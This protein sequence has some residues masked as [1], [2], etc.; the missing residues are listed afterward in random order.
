M[1][2]VIQ[3]QARRCSSV[4]VHDILPRP[5]ED[6][7]PTPIPRTDRDG[8]IPH[9]HTRSKSFNIGYR[10]GLLSKKV[11]FKAQG[12]LK[13]SDVGNDVPARSSKDVFDAV[14]A[15]EAQHAGVVGPKRGI[16]NEGNTCFLGVLVQCL[17]ATP[18]LA[19]ALASSTNETVVSQE[20]DSEEGQTPETSLL[21]ALHHIADSLHA[22]K[23]DE[24]SVRITPL[25]QALKKT[26]VAAEYFNNQQ[27]DVQEVLMMVL[28][29][30]DSELC[31][32]KDDAN[33]DTSAAVN[34]WNMKQT[35][36]IISET[37]LGQLK[38]SVLCEKCNKCFTMDEPFLELSLSI[39]PNPSNKGLLSWLGFNSLTLG[40]SLFEY[41]SGDVLEGDELFSCDHCECKTKATKRLAIHSLPPALILHLK[42]FKYTSKLTSEKIDKMVTFPLQGLDLREHLAKGSPHKPEECIYDLYAVAEHKGNLT[43]G[44]YTALVLSK[45]ETNESNDFCWMHCNDEIIKKVGKQFVVSPNAYLLFYMRRRFV[46]PTAAAI[47]YRNLDQIQRKRHTS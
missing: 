7:G 17:L 23:A 14:K 2:G 31:G 9:R 34:Q 20:H 8:H 47:A 6:F 19:R 3:G 45:D 35:S 15:L 28:D 13:D 30:L 43:T 33:H 38:S 26:P 29:L 5:G 37:F 42:R 41:T 27:Q 46:D 12:N 18:G 36:S 39:A 4:D 40:D 1:D 25:I 10:L 44:H 11:S 22:G 32:D 16:V 21:R 24:T